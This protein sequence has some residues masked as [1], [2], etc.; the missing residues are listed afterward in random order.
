MVKLERNAGTDNEQKGDTMIEFGGWRVVADE[1]AES[2]ACESLIT[3][4]GRVWMLNGYFLPSSELTLF[5]TQ[6]SK[7]CGNTGSL[8][9]STDEGKLICP[10]CK[11]EFRRHT[12]A[13]QSSYFV[14]TGIVREIASYYNLTK[15]VL[16]QYS[17]LFT[18]RYN[19]V[20]GVNELYAAI[21]DHVESVYVRLNR[22]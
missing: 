5:I 11:V 20:V 7:C 10:L 9:F 1:E 17:G 12:D 19:A 18:D 13:L 8:D 15:E 22:A 2:Q 14:P 6:G 4:F 21:S 16:E 3:M